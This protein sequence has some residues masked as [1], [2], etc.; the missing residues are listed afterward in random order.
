MQNEAHNVN[1]EREKRKMGSGIDM[2][3]LRKV[4]L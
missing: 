4:N 1:N 2:N 3:V